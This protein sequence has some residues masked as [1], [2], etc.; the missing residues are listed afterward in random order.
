MDN[1]F[2]EVFPLFDPL[3]HEFSPENRIIDIF[4]S[5]FSFHTFSKCN[6]KDLNKCIQQFDD[7]AIEASGIPSIALI[8]SDV[9]IKN[10]VATSISH[11]HI[12][13]KPITKM[14]HHAVNVTSTEAELFAIKCSINQPI[15]YNK[16]SKII[17]VTG[18]IHAARKIFNSLLHLF[19]QQLAVVLKEL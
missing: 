10:N 14:L 18:Y 11:I 2:N 12:Y 5:H 4:A 6:D 3:N 8:V 17:V 19:Q 16:I 15:H 1:Q 13:N 9:S 7:L